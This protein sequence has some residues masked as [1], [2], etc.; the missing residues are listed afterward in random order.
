[1]KSNPILI[2]GA[3]GYVGARLIPLLLERQYRIRAA[4]RNLEKLRSYSWAKHPSVE[5]TT[6][7]AMDLESM[8]IACKG[9]WCAYYLIHSM[10]P[11]HRDFADADRKAAH[12]MITAAGESK[13]D[14]LVYLG[15]L[16]SDDLN[17]S[18]HLRSRAEVGQIL[19]T[20]RVPIT[21]FKAGMIIGSGSA[22]FEILRYLVDRLP[23][24][25]TPRWVN[26]I[27]QPI[28]IRN[29]L[30]Y[31]SSCLEKSETLGQSFEIGGRDI[32]TYRRLMEIYAEEAHLS[33]RLV[34][35]VP[36]LTPR[37]SSYWIH[38][39]TPVP[40]YIAKPL[41]EGLRNPVV[42][43]EERIR[44]IIPQELLDCREAIRL[45]LDETQHH[46]IESKWTDAGVVP[47]SEWSHTGDPSW[48]GG[49]ILE[50][51][52]T[53][54]FHGGQ[55]EAW[56][57]IGGI[58]GERGWYYANWLWRL[59][60]FMDR[61]VGGVG[62]RRGRRHP[63]DL[64]PGDALDFWRVVKVDPPHQLL[65]AAEMKLPGRAVLD[66]TIKEIDSNTVEVTQ[67]AR[68]Q[69]RGLWGMLYW[70]II[71]PFHRMVFKGMLSGICRSAGKT[72]I[73]NPREMRV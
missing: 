23:I 63:S 53:M 21:E 61:I 2:T 70:Y 41:A 58:G 60:G 34:I 54:I 20:G 4:G 48:S 51:K 50:N 59:R 31:L 35:P 40:G 66:F 12:N 28:A 22:S 73:K 30:E 33:K 64:R 5:C 18:K 49:T 37:L 44:K 25:V 24:M 27:S 55:K 69:P 3:T 15:G 38:L 11:D 16:G 14:R 19:K 39:V 47:P 1:M 9:C 52:Q 72:R 29:V 13:L 56:E 71:Y 68:F 32:L 62:L 26:T 46:L 57:T 45:A 42:C 7:D 43:K 67:T 10:N 6:A 36:V 17:L 8:R 65:L